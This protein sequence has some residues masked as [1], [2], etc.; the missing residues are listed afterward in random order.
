MNRRLR[1]SAL[2]VSI[3]F[4][5]PAPMSAVEPAGLISRSHWRAEPPTRPYEEHTISRITVHHQGVRALKRQ[6]AAKRMRIMQE[7]HQSEA[8]GFADVAYHFVIDRKGR[9]YE[10][11]PLSA[12]GESKTDYDPT[13]HLLICLLGDF[14]VQEPTAEQLQTLR[15]LLQWG[16]SEFRLSPDTV[17]GHRDYARSDCP[18][19]NLYK[20]LPKLV[21]ELSAE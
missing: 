15:A 11:R 16:L 3:A 2:A 12:P 13:G 17:K 4:T 21:A 20:L 18:G 5:L 8:R 10:G 9:L 14:R 6:D 7:Y 1:L 19:E